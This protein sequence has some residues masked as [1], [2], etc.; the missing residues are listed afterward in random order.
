MSLTDWTD[1]E[2]HDHAEGCREATCPRHGR[3]VI[4]L[5]RRGINH[6]RW[7]GGPAE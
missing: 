1:I 3:Y 7:P 2:L 5:A 4:E 6:L